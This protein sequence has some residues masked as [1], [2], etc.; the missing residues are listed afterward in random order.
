MASA[1]SALANAT[2]TLSVPAE[3]TVTDAETGN[4]LPITTTVTYSLFLRSTSKSVDELPG[5]N[6][7]TAIYEGYC[8][9]PQALDS[10]V[11]EGTLG[12]LN[13]AGQGSFECKVLRARYDYGSQGLL[14]QALQ[15][16]L[17]D[18]IRLQQLRAL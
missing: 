17:G 9:N 4:V 10:G 8:V 16:A 3:G 1:L 7:D 2:L 14:G 12:E 11:L 15:G 13:F 6:A 5:I 18:R